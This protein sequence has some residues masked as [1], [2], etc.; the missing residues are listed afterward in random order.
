M[1][2]NVIKR[3]GRTVLFDKSLVRGAI[4]KAMKEVGEI[5]FY[6]PTLLL[7]KLRTINLIFLT[8]TAFK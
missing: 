3:D 4:T 1:V 6:S 8:L 5:D 2:Q 7:I